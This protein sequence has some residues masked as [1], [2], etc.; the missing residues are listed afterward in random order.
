MGDF[1]WSG[2]MK[3][4]LALITIAI[5]MMLTGSAFAQRY[6]SSWADEYITEAENYGIIPE[7]IENGNLTE[8]ITRE[9][10]CELAYLTIDN[11][12]KNNGIKITYT[13]KE[14]RFYDTDNEAVNKLKKMD[15]I[16]G[17]TSTK[18]DPDALITREEAA[19]ILQRMVKYVGLTTFKNSDGFK[20]RNSIS[21]WARES[22]DVVCGMN[23]M[24]GMGN[25]NF[26]PKESYTKEQAVSTM[27]RL[28]NNMPDKNSRE[29]ISDNR[30]YTFNKYFMWIENGSGTVI[31]KLSKDKYSAI[32]FYSNGEKLL[33]FA[34]GSGFTDVY[35]I[36]S[37]KKLFGISAD[38]VGTTADKY[39]IAKAENEELYGIY[40]FKGNTVVPVEYSWE[41]LY[42]EKY[43]K[44]EKNY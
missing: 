8:G 25:G 28:I 9:Q 40:D 18:F 30:Y 15:I 23:I 21:S 27:I 22:V 17:K 7:S 35:D 3:K 5:S 32:N 26:E 6:Y 41:Y 36:D 34:V 14:A 20:D 31:F 42:N 16:S 39:I 19:S 10:F 38:V 37:G 13:S 24:S 11:L 1:L 43:I 44:T 4:R 2:Y 33:A 29:K 12:A